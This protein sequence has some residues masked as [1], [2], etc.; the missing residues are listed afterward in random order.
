M[1]YSANVTTVLTRSAQN[2]A[3]ASMRRKRSDDTR[4]HKDAR[5]VPSGAAILRPA[6]TEALTRALFEEW[7]RTGYAALSL[8]AVAK[9]ASVGK[10]ALYR[11]WPSKAA[12][13]SDLLEAAG[14]RVTLFRDTGSLEGDVR[15]LLHAFRRAL[16][17]PLVR[18]ILPDMH[19]EV[20]R[21]D[22]IAAVVARMAAA[23]R[24]RGEEMLARAV[25]RGELRAGLDMGLANDVLA[26]IL[27]WRIVAIRGR[28]DR[29]YLEHLARVVLA[30]LRAA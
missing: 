11:R 24:A 30:A 7:A 2:L 29:D 18:R 10:A 26:G 17:H 22:D 14:L 23:R 3:R 16:R 9:R 19:A 4:D 13:V 1:R 6:V 28:T 20:Q 5:R 21:S 12:M 25:A 15:A 8:E 27:H